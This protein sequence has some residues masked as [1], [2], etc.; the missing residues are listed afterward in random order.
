M[1]H[2][3]CSIFQ[4]MGNVSGRLLNTFQDQMAPSGLLLR[5]R[6]TLMGS[7][8]G[9]VPIFNANETIS[10]LPECTVYWR[11]LFADSP[12][13]LHNRRYF[14]ARHLRRLWKITPLRSTVWYASGYNCALSVSA[15]INYHADMMSTLGGSIT[16][17][18][19]RRNHPRLNKPVPPW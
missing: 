1:G 17:K 12:P 10:A 15:V 8:V 14:C 16:L 3:F 7:I 13:H 4:F 9:E 6:G 19:Q 5:T 2:I 11:I 18:H